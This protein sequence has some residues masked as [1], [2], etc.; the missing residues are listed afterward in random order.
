M[1]IDHQAITGILRE[2]ATREILPLW[3]N[4]HQHHI[5]QKQPGDLVTVADRACE[6]FISR[7]LLSLMPG[8]LV[9]G[10]EA[11]HHDPGLMLALESTRPVWVIDPLDGTGN[12]AAGEGP[13]AVM[14]CLVHQRETLAAWI[15][16]PV[17]NTMLEAELGA[18]AQLD[19]SHLAI[20]AYTGETGDICGALST[21]YLPGKLRDPAIKGAR[22]LGM[23][24]ASGCAGSDYRALARGEYQF[25]FYY[26]T[27]VWDHA[28]G[29]LIVSEAGAHAG[30]YDG[31]N[32]RPGPGGTGL[33]C[34]ADRTTWN[35]VRNLL[36]PSE[37]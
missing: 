27:L 22:Q 33:I 3:Q 13:I 21:K 14:V 26:R 10:E 1:N 2:A 35:T 34:A 28:P 11:V 15:F 32:Y 36:V 5:E 23:T 8:S 25:V 19:G 37:M 9:I 29:V 20:D 17:E 31:A 4:L 6:E 12:F 24:V 16:D 18:G 30:R 7:E